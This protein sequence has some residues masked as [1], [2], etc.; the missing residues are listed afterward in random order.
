MGVSALSDQLAATALTTGERLGSDDARRSTQIATTD[1]FLTSDRQ[2]HSWEE[3]PIL[4]VRDSAAWPLAPKTV[5][6]S[7][8]AVGWAV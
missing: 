4:C 7:A 5:L 6:L 1:G 3:Q 2:W 8:G